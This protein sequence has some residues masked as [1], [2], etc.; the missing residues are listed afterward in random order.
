MKIDGADKRFITGMRVSANITAEQRKAFVVQRQAVLN[1]EKGDYLFQVSKAK[2]HRVEVETVVDN[3]SL[4]GV[5]GELDPHDPV[6]I[7][8]NY[9]LEDGMSVR[10]GSR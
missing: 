4:L 9:E 2:A 10:E 1:D 7:L 6:V 8:G 3:S 5:T